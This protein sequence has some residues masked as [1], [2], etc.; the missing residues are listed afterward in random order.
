MD[1]VKKPRVVE[2]KAS[3]MKDFQKQ[4]FEMREMR[5]T[6]QELDNEA[7]TKLL[8]LPKVTLEQLFQQSKDNDD[9]ILDIMSEQSHYVN[10]IEGYPD[11]MSLKQSGRSQDNIINKKTTTD[12][13]NNK[14]INNKTSSK[15]GQKSNVSASVT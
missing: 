12:R 5:Y 6:D 9:V 2:K 7:F 13:L 14:D 3:L 15:S 10:L 1:D 11:L 4:G 8:G